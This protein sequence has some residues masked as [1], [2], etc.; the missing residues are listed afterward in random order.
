[1][2]SQVNS[3]LFNEQVCQILTPRKKCNL[4][5][6][7]MSTAPGLTFGSRPVTETLAENDPSMLNTTISV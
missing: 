6:L 7:T 4:Y 5:Y 3:I 1:M 2:P